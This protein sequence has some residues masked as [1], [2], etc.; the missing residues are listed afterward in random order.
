MNIKSFCI[1]SG[2]LLILAIP[3][4]LPYE[5]YTL[6]RWIVCI[7]SIFVGYEFYKSKLNG[8]AFVF[9][10]LAYLFNPLLPVYLN[11]GTWILIDLI[12][13]ILFFI[14]GYSAKKKL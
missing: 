9:G 1:L 12:S 8:W 6:L 13:A 11:K 2:A 4:W 5:F 14:A 3:Y 7:A 10:A